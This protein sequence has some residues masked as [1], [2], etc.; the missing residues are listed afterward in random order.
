MKN[1][2]HIGLKLPWE[3]E[4][5]LLS[6]NFSFSHNVFYSEISLVRQNAALCG[7]GLTLSH[8]RP[9]F[10]VSAVQVFWKHGGKKEKLL[11]TSNFSFSHSVFYQF[12]E[13]F[14]IFIKFEI[15]VCKLFQFGRVLNLLFGDGLRTHFY[16]VGYS[17][18]FLSVLMPHKYISNKPMYSTAFGNIV[19]KR[20]FYFQNHF[21]IFHLCF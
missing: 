16:P 15:A 6:S 13:L 12:W 5:L 21:P 18:T 19:R 10:N 11:V 17:F 14:A 20:R 9:G 1:K 7:N 3:K 4:K 8:S 2:W